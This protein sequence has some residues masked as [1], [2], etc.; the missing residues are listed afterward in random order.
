MELFEIIFNEQKGLRSEKG[1]AGVNL[2]FIVL[3]FD[4]QSHENLI[5]ISKLLPFVRLF[6]PPSTCL[7]KGRLISRI[8]IEEILL[9]SK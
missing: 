9:P 6:S 8:L 2:T 4:T 1:R 3:I 7:I 5:R